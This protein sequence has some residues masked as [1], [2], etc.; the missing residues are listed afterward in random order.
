MTNFSPFT[1]VQ[2]WIYCDAIFLHFH[3]F[4]FSVF[5]GARANRLKQNLYIFFNFN[6]R[7]VTFS[8]RYPVKVLF[9]NNNTIS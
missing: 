4:I 3:I 7:Y 9:V 1:I 5:F 2:K 6:C 8:I